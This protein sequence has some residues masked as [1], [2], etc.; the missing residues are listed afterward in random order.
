MRGGLPTPKRRPEAPALFPPCPQIYTAQLAGR[1]A[2][3]S[4]Q[5]SVTGK[6]VPAAVGCPRLAWGWLPAHCPPLQPS[7][8]FSSLAAG[9][10]AVFYPRNLA[11]AVTATHISGTPVDNWC[12]GSGGEGV[13]PCSRQPLISCPARCAAAG[14]AAGTTQMCETPICG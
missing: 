6:W 3:S 2:A 9:D 11:W 8:G 13:G 5:S 14:C 12:G 4:I 10:F 7:A 1:L